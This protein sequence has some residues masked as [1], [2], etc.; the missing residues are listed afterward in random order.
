MARIATDVAGHVDGVAAPRRQRVPRAAF[1]RDVVSPWPAVLVLAAGVLATVVV[2]LV[3]TAWRESETERTARSVANG[4]RRLVEARV[5][6]QLVALRQLAVVW[7]RATNVDGMAWKGDCNLFLQQHPG[8]ALVAWMEA[9]KGDSDPAHDVVRLVRTGDEIHRLVVASAAVRDRLEA[10]TLPVEL[11]AARSAARTSRSTALV[12]PFALAEGQP[13]C[14]VSVPL[15][16][17]PGR[18][19]YHDMLVA[20][21]EP[22]VLLTELLEGIAPGYRIRITNERGALH[23]RAPEGDSAANLATWDVSGEPVRLDTGATW[24]L[25]LTRSA[26]LLQSR[27]PAMETTVFATGIAIS[28]LLAVVLHLGQVARVRAQALA[29]TNREL[30]ARVREAVAAHD[31]FR[32]LNAELEARVADSTR[33]QD[34]E[35]SDLATFK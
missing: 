24:R 11:A 1:W 31:R 17:T 5:N 30:Q 20:L 21:F 23:S 18:E 15:D 29:H 14:Q 32:L 34:A 35:V 10:M 28:I 8:I 9:E 22:A 19:N 25:D 4:V 33:T 3:L 12:G 6:D 2:W 7:S 26:Q 27:A 16:E 13:I